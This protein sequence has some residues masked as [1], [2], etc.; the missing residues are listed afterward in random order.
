MKVRKIGGREE[1]FAIEKI[2]N[3]VKKQTILLKNK[4]E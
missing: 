1:D 3:A 4:K 2:I